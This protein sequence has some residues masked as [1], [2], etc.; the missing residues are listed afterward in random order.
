MSALISRRRWLS[1]ACCFLCMM[2]LSTSTRSERGPA[3]PLISTGAEILVSTD[4]AA[5]EGQRVGL[6]TNQTGLVGSKH[7]ADLLHA[8]SN[9]DLVAIFAPEHGFRGAVEAGESIRDGVDTKTGV[10]VYSLYGATKKPTARMLRGI[11]ILI[12]DIQDVG[13]R[14]YTY[15]STMGLAMEAA[16]AAGIPFLILDRPNPL[17]GMYVSGFVLEPRRRSFVG[18]YPIPIVHGLTVAELARMIQGEAWRSGLDKLDLRVIAMRGWERSMRWHKTEQPWV[19][20]SPNVPTFKSALVYPGI[21]IIGETQLVNE[22]RG[23]EEPFTVF[24]AP[25]LNA[26]RMAGR[27]NGLG[28][29]GVEFKAV[30]YKPRSIPRVAKNPVFVNRTIHGVRVVV[31]DMNR[32]QPL[33]VGIQALTLLIREARSRGVAPLIKKISMFDAIAGTRRLRKMLL[34]GATGASIIAAW[35]KEVERFKERSVGYRLY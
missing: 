12:F 3:P 9:V 27:L 8:A 22:G 5:I 23:T 7:L 15:I 25:W 13:A 11:D 34:N 30:R 20:T 21:G 28:L 1:T 26:R 19:P 35:R 29:P 10:R 6:I 2:I 33:E 16:A 4:F 14:F 17:G 32:Y 24:G 18:L 31:T